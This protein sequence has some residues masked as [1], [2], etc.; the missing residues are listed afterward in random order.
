MVVSGGEVGTGKYP[1]DLREASYSE[2]MDAFRYAHENEGKNYYQDIF[3][4]RP[5]L[6][7]SSSEGGVFHSKSYNNGVKIV[8]VVPEPQQRT[9][10]DVV[11][12]YY[13]TVPPSKSSQKRG[14]DVDE[15]K[16][17]TKNISGGRYP[18]P[19]TIAIF[20]GGVNSLSTERLATIFFSDIKTFK[21]WK[22]YIKGD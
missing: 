21:K 12:P 4:F 17:S 19:Y 11:E 10:I 22:A 16:I 6:K 14:W 1:L 20:A 18:F 5:D 15:D 8:F 3:D 7:R 9:M 13:P 2:I